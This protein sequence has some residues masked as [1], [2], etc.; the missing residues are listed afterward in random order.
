MAFSLD[1]RLKLR[2]LKDFRGYFI[3]LIDAKEIA[4]PELEILQNYFPEIKNDSQLSRAR[5]VAI[6][7]SLRNKLSIKDD[8]GQMIDLHKKLFTGAGIYG[9]K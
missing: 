7:N 4:V 8:A 3:E 2:I 9:H 1:P 5:A 6:V